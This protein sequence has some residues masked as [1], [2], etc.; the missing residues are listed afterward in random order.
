VNITINAE[1]LIMQDTPRSEVRVAERVEIFHEQYGNDID[2]GS[3]LA[4]LV[5]AAGDFISRIVGS[6]NAD[7]GMAKIVERVVTVS[8]NMM[9]EPSDWRRALDD[10]RANCFSEW[11][12]GEL[13]HDL[14]AYAVYGI[15]LDGSYD[16]DELAQHIEKLVKEA[17]E[18]VA[19]TPFVQWQIGSATT[20]ESDLF[21]LVRLAGNRW[22]LDNDR[23]VE[24]AALAEFGGVSE[25]R[26]RNMMS[27]TK[28]TFSAEDGRI[29]ALEALA[30][31]NG[32]KEFWNS[33]WREQ[34][35]P[36]YG[37][38]RRPPLERAVF[39]PVARDGSMFHPGLRRGAG[40]TVGEKGS[41]TQIADFD[42]ALAALQRMPTPYWR[43]PNSSGNWGIVSGVRWERLDTSDLA[44]LASH[45]EYRITGDEHA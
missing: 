31:L 28:R 6:E 2:A 33:I 40:Y 45:P 12:L 35:L 30:W 38:K 27:G 4:A 23:P 11:P 42:E 22:A 29:P 15:V 5:I 21:R 7:I 1:S 9:E 20:S 25:G 43:R 14:A 44:I 32:R 26:I 19:A 37:T 16:E 18:F 34:Q 39:V 13:L 8:G 36:Q 24:P 10:S 41:E 17:E 3:T